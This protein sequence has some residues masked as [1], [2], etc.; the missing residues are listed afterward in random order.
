MNKYDSI[1]NLPHYEPK[2]H[3]R[4]PMENRAAQFAPFSA[5]EG[6]DEALRATA[7]QRLK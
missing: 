6:H 4:M 2:R 3:A 1:I 7:E 5:L